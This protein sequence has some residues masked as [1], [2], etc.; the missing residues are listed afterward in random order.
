MNTDWKSKIGINILIGDFNE[1]PYR[2]WGEA[3]VY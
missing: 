1:N 2:S 3:A